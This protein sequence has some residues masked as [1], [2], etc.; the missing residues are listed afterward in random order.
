[1][2]FTLCAFDVVVTSMAA[3][4]WWQTARDVSRNYLRVCT[5]TMLYNLLL[6]CIV[7]YCIALY[8]V[9][10]CLL[11][12]LQQVRLVVDSCEVAGIVESDT[13][14]TSMEDRR[15][16]EAVSETPG[17]GRY[18]SISTPLQ[19]GGRSDADIV[20]PANVARDGFN[21]CIKNVVHN[22]QVLAFS[23]FF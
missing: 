5:T 18:L 17:E 12:T 15:A 1:M 2:N 11:I 6:Y 3:I 13:E 10:L 7:V 14:Q 21:G 16:C 4:G 9:V 19:L 23:C 22:G 20:Y 8:C